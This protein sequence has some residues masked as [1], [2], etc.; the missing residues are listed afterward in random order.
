MDLDPCEGSVS[1]SVSPVFL[2]LG[3]RL[4]SVLHQD[5]LKC[6]KHL[7]KYSSIK[8][9]DILHPTSSWKTSTSDTIDDP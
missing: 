7:Y 2:P 1:Q 6:S 4:I 9:N 8:L 3:V 5:D